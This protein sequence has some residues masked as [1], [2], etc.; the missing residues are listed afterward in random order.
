[1]IRYRELILNLYYDFLI[2]NNLDVEYGFK[3][4]LSGEKR[5]IPNVNYL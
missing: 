5:N 4:S 3:T 2:L 1:M